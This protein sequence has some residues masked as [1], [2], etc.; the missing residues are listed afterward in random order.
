MR[1]TVSQKKRP[2]KFYA[3]NILGNFIPSRPT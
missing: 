2:F 1:T 3:T